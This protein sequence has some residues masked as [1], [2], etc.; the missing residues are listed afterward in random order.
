MHITQSCSTGVWRAPEHTVSHAVI[1][2]AVAVYVF[3]PGTS[4]MLSVSASPAVLCHAG[5]KDPYCSDW[6]SL[7]LECVPT[8]SCGTA[9]TDA[10]RLVYQRT[11]TRPHTRTNAIP[12]ASPHSKLKGRVDSYSQDSVADQK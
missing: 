4:L 9:R 1:A 6:L 8:R 10:N 7:P 3:L 5:K 2:W 11:K 12:R